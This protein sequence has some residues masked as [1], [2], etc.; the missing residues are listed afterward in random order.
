MANVGESTAGNVGKLGVGAVAV[1]GEGIVTPGGFNPAQLAGLQLWY[2]VSDLTTLFQDDG[3]TTPVTA[4]GQSVAVIHDKSGNGYHGAQTISARRPVYKTDGTYHWLQFN[5]AANQSF[6]ISNS[7]QGAVSSDNTIVMGVMATSTIQGFIY[8][9]TPEAG[10]EFLMNGAK[11]RPAIATTVGTTAPT[12][13]TT[14]TTNTKRVCS[15][16]WK[17]STATLRGWQNQNLEVSQAVSAADKKAP[18][19][20]WLGAGFAVTGFCYYGNLYNIC[21][22]DVQLSDTDRGTLESYIADE[23]GVTL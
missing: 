6:V 12:T 23:T 1:G 7:W 4:D 9:S 5:G 21:S 18:T 19:T 17:R 2:D 13:A 15:S 16:D 3:A 8:G 14:V 20:S 11:I 10:L 22:Y